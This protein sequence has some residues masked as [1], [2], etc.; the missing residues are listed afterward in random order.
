M[1]RDHGIEHRLE[2]ILN[3]RHTPEEVCADSPELLPDVIARWRQLRNIEAELLALFPP[4]AEV[5]TGGLDDL[6][7]P[8]HAFATLPAIPG[9]DVTEM[10]GNG[11]MG[12]V[13]KAEHHKLNR[14]VAIKMLLASAYA[15]PQEVASLSRE[16]QAMA[17]LR[18]ANIV[19]VYDVG[20]IDGRP[21]FSMEYM[22]GGTLALSLAGKP[23]PPRDAAAL[24]IVL[25][26][27]VQAVHDAGIVHRDIKP[28]N[29][30]LGGD[31]TP[32]L[33]D[34]S[35]ARAFASGKTLSGNPVVGTP[36]YMAPE[37]V[38][39]K[40][41]SVSPSV[42]IYA[43]GALLYELLTGRPP[44]RSESSAATLRQVVEE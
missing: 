9:Y 18:H 30:L 26:S 22:A 43:L 7:S 40:P 33:A 23:R 6:P 17:A 25:A 42:D 8:T 3:S 29:V 14:T 16:A 10:L 20:D 36:S 35:L 5:P 41:E 13:Y 38:I 15:T 37:Q 34:C 21:Y 11:G 1:P 31:G 39:G 27:A 44:F 19:Q 4:T 12:I 24:A 2:E 28:A 32:K